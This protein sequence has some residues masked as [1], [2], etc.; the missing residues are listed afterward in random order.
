LSWGYPEVRAYKVRT[1]ARLVKT[2]G[3]DGVLLDYCRY[4]GKA[5][6]V[7]L[8]GLAKLQTLSLGLGA[9]QVT[10]AGV[11]ELMKALPK[12]EITK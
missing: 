4:L 1:I 7:H 9:S 11:A 8:K 5:A 12:C 6:L 2:S 3:V 10:D